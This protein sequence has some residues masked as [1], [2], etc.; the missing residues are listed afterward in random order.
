MDE[1]FISISRIVD[2]YVQHF[3]NDDVESWRRE[4]LGDGYPTTVSPGDMIHDLLVTQF[5]DLTLAAVEC[6]E[7]GRLWFQ[8]K[9][10]TNRYHAYVPEVDAEKRTKKL[11]DFKSQDER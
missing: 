1:F 10:N 6:D 8:E 9:P 2:S 7:C 3:A 5:L 11:G 4:H